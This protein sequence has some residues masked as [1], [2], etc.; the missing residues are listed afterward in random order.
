VVVSLGLSALLLAAWFGVARSQAAG[1]LTRLTFATD[2]DRDSSAPDLTFDG[3]LVAFHSDADFLGSG[4]PDDQFEI[5]LYDTQSLTSTRVTTASG[6][7]RHSWLPDLSADGGVLAFQSDSDFFG[8]GIQEDQEEIWLYNTHTLSLTRVTFGNSGGVD[9]RTP[10]LSGD[11]AVVAFR[12]TADLLGEGRPANVEEVWLYDTAAMTYTRVTSSSGALRGS[13]G[14]S[15]SQDG[16]WLAFYSDADFLGEGIA[17]NQ[18]EIWLYETATQQLTRLTS[19]S[20]SDRAS[21]SPSLSADGTRVAF[22]SDSDFLGQGIPDDQFEIWLYDTQAMTVTRV[23][24]ASHPN[25][26]SIFAELSADGTVVAFRSDSDFLGEGIA[27]GQ[28]E[29][30]LYD[31][32][33][34][35][36]TR[37]TTATDAARD[38]WA[39][40]LS[41][42]GTRLA[43]YS[44]SDFQGA[45]IPDDQLEVRLYAVP[46]RIYLP[47]IRR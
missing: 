14:P 32:A 13:F 28:S 35:T 2:G 30:W 11:G 39:P 46:V 42:G 3:R 10:S 33:V 41:A 16:A 44:D 7:S 37:I 17:D 22:Y 19:A 24:T 47:I 40:S 23:T 45:G 12:S 25:R 6:A 4:I 36:Y 38:S 34:L 5:W 21:F 8:Q 20:G 9:S 15:I 43:F 27:V 26:G 18:N 31:T 1:K 29:I